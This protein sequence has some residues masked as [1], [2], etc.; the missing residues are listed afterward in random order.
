LRKKTKI[1]FVDSNYDL[2]FFFSRLAQTAM[3]LKNIIIADCTTH[4]YFFYIFYIMGCTTLNTIFFK[5]ILWFVQ[6]AMHLNFFCIAN[7]KNKYNCFLKYIAVCTTRNA[8]KIFLY[9]G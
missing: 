1:A 3:Q 8:F 2:F 6:A 4:N 7:K 9:C 5:N